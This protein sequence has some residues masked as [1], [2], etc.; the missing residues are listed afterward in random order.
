MATIF[1]YNVEAM[2]G[3]KISIVFNNNKAIVV[4]LLNLV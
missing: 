4:V 1:I 2:H 3:G